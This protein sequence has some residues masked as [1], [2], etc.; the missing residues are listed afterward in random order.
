[1][2]NLNFQRIIPVLLPVRAVGMNGARL[3][4]KAQLATLYGC[5]AL[6]A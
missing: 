4:A 1:L 5:D 6:K 3:F 2:E